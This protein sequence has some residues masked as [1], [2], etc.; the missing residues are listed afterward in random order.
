MQNGKSAI[1]IGY[2]EL[3][4]PLWGRGPY[5]KNEVPVG[6]VVV[7]NNEIV[8]RGH[9]IK[10]TK[11]DTT[12]HAEIIAIQKASKKMNAWRLEDCT[13][14][15]T[16]EP[17]MMCMG[18]IIESRIKSVYYG[19]ERNTKQMYDKVTVNSFISMKKINNIECS[20]LLSDFFEKK[21]K[22]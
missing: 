18:A 9:N 21:R 8:A 3:I 13:M 12:K 22:K 7:K 4:R 14:Y 6:A 17:C 19:T 1:I 10:E 20:K 16:L 5:Q 11:K 15:V 2:Q